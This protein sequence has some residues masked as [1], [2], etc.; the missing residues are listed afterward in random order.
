MTNEQILLLLKPL[1]KFK[2]GRQML[3]FIRNFL[4]TVI[5]QAEELERYDE[6]FRFI[7][8]HYQTQPEMEKEYI[9]KTNDE[10]FERIQKH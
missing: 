5:R 2:A 3:R 9:G 6:F 10:I 1:S 8:T 7:G 4:N